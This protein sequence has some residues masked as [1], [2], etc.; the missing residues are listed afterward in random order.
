MPDAV[1]RRGVEVA[2]AAVPGR[3]QGLPGG[4]VVKR[5]EQPTQRPTTK[6]ELGDL[7]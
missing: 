4:L 3:R 6:T 2:D 7:Y 5:R 1:V